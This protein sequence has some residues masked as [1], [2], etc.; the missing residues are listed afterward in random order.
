M[1]ILSSFVPGGLIAVIIAVVIIAVIIFAAGYVKAAPDTA[2]I[3][4]GLGKRKILIGKAGFR[5]PFLQRIDKLSLRVFQVDIK[6]DEAIPTSN[7]INIR[8][9]GVAN[10]KISSDPELLNRAAES[11]LNMS[12]S[13]L[14][15]QVQQVLQGNMREIIGTVDIKQLVQDRQGVANSVK[16]NVVPDMAKMG[17]EV[18]NFN[19]Q[20]FSDDNHVI[21]N[22]G[23]DNIA[24]I[25]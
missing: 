10:L 5:W 21:E 8:V 22:L 15:A 1:N 18:V 2:I 11:I 17:I 16:E 4:S 20:S 25:S 6:T 7:F 23:I 13:N 3:I 24:Q 12:E 19:I 9:D 14:I